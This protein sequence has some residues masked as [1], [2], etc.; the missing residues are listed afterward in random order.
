MH[1]PKTSTELTA[2][3]T[4]TAAAAPDR[5]TLYPAIEP[6]KT[7]T[8]AVGDGHVLFYEE[9]GNPS[10]EPVLLIHGGPG[11]GANPTM[12]RFHDPAHHRIIL[13]DQRG[14]G[15]ST[16]YASLDH[17]TTWHLVADM[18]LLR[19]HLSVNRWQLF[20]GSWGSTLAIAYA[21]THP[22]RVTGMILRGIF[23]LRR[24]E[25]DWFYQQGASA[26]YPDAFEE[27][28]SVIPSAE[29]GDLVAAFHRRLTGTDKAE[30]LR[31][32]KAWSIW[33]G[34]TLAM[35]QD[36]ARIRAFGSD[37]YAIAFARIECHYFINGGFLEHDNQ[38]LDNAH[39]LHA[40]PGIIV[41]GR[42]DMVTPLANAWAL[43]KAW[44]QADLRI[45]PDAGHAM[46]ERGNMHELVA[47]TRHFMAQRHSS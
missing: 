28:Q 21:Q 13:F 9:C 47:A 6:Y 37:H 2:T 5:L 7:G 34:S 23:L 29:R 22:E 12:R 27:F 17:N 40:I 11:G 41:H 25:I 8:L 20:G 33:E 32:A 35:R 46:T 26:I 19:K 4:A 16:P 1:T 30:Q 45:V 18:E 31:A 43:H 14:S 36:E 44:P 3:Q 10:G 39:R 38:L 15:R 42:F 24:R